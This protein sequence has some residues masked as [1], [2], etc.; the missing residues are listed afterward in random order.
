M[1]YEVKWVISERKK[2]VYYCGDNKW[3]TNAHKAM[4]FNDFRSAQVH[5]ILH[6]NRKFDVV[7]ISISCNPQNKLIE[8]YNKA[9]RGVV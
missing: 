4:A 7:R 9:M 3:S 5:G 6:T 8:A 1:S 2:R